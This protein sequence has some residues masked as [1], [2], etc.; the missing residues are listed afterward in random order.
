MNEEKALAVILI[1]KKI[2]LTLSIINP[3]TKTTIKQINIKIIN[4]LLI[5][6]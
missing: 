4:I 1:L 6:G 3:V 2:A 5:K